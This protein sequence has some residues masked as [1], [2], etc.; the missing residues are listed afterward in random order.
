MPYTELL[1]RSGWEIVESVDVTPGFADITRRDLAA[2][3][4]RASRLR[5]LVGEVELADRLALKRARVAGLADDLIR[6]EL[7]FVRAA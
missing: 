6:R 3:A 1:A 7:F 4:A 2:F 5:E